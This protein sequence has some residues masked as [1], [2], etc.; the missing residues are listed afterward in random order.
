MLNLFS[1]EYFDTYYIIFIAFV[2]LMYFINNN[3]SQ[4]LIIYIY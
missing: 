1:C 2:Y 3:D 4:Y